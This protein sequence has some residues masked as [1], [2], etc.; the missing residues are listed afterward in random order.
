MEIP[1]LHKLVSLSGYSSDTKSVISIEV[2]DYCVF[3]QKL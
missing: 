3:Q 1:Q 2:T